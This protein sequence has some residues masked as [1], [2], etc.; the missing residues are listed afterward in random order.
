VLELVAR[1]LK[2]NTVG[3][4]D[5]VDESPSASIWNDLALAEINLT[6]RSHPY[7]AQRTLRDPRCLRAR[8][9]RRASWAVARKSCGEE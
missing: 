4:D 2:T 6:E 9:W 8:P 7:A 3:R 5:H 1:T